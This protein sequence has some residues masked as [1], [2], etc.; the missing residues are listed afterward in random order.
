MKGKSR[1]PHCKE[2]VVVD[3]P[4][5][6]S[7]EQVVTCPNCGMKFK[8]NVDEKYSWESEAPMIHPSVHLK[9]R[10]MK[11]VI[12]GILLVIIFLSGIAMSGI[13]L[14]SLDSLSNINVPSEFEGKVVDSGGKAL[15]SI[16]VSVVGHP[17]IHA[18]TD[19]NGKFLI[20]NITSGK[21]TL[22]FTGDGY[23][24][25][26]AKVFV[27]PW[28]ITLPYDKF[29]MGNE[30]R[31]QKSLIIKVFDLRVALSAFIIAMSTAAL[32]GG[33][34]AIARKRFGIALI[35]AVLGTISGM[36]TVVGIVL[37]IIAIVLLLLSKDEFESKPREVKY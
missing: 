24:N 26:T 22:I 6:L 37:G 31:E 30:Q 36:F 13:L 18:V 14:F 4:D 21:Q 12:A 25:L 35:G 23:G 9:T 20:K 8:V 27:L 17:E 33:I 29:V 3:V 16:N 10:S 1:C 32:V 28:N 7:G 34:A 11:P 5:G 15:E 19:S 2:S